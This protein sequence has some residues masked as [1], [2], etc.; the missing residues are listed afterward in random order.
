M[1]GR[2]TDVPGV[3]V[4]HRTL[5]QGDICTGVTAILPHGGDVFRDR[6]TAASYVLNG[7]GK[8]IGLMQLDELGQIETPILL[9]NTLAVG[10]CANALIRRAIAQNPSI[11]RHLA[12]VNPVVAECN[13]GYLNNIQAMAVTEADVDAALDLAET[14]FASGAV[15]AGTGMSCFGFKG[16]IGTASAAIVLDGM[17]RQLGV[18]ALCN[19][20]RP[21]D[22][23]P[24]GGRPALSPGAPA[25]EN[26]SVVVVMA[27]DIPL[28]HR[29]LSRVIR[30][31]GIGLARLG[32]FWGHGSGDVFIGFSTAN[33]RLVAAS[34][35]LLPMQV[36]AEPRIDQLFEAMAHVTEEAVLDALTSAETTTGRSGHVRH[37]LRSIGEGA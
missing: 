37:S 33:R 30:R 32:S 7:F 2:I 23:R 13:D 12:T 17:P 36:L 34:S 10:T 16:G 22:L 18:L 19:F 6:P 11:G 5:K 24:P 15:G 26:G 35:D 8:S 28:E 14:E 29:Q 20:G 27:T 9:T 25:P 1:T 21:G 31:G 4:G 3:R